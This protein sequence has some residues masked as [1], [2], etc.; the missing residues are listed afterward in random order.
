M[1]AGVGT[2]A[3]AAVLLLLLAAKGIATMIL[4]LDGVAGGVGAMEFVRTE[5]IGVVADATVVEVTVGVD[6]VEVVVIL[7]VVLLELDELTF[8]VEGV[9]GVVADTVDIDVVEVA[10]DAA[11]VV[12][13][14]EV[15]VEVVVVVV[16]GVLAAFT[17]FVVTG[18][19][20][21]LMM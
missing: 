5:E 12:M 15:E 11:M 2:R 1:L 16:E 10:G 20:C 4:G 14:A 21:G 19:I 6:G 13:M 9:V 7:E 3:G 18:V 8:G 17:I